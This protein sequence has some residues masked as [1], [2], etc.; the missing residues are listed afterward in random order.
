[1]ND[2]ARADSGTARLVDSDGRALDAT[3]H[4][5]DSDSILVVGF[6]DFVRVEMRLAVTQDALVGSAAARSDAATERDSAGH[7]VPFR[8][9]WTMEARRT[10]CDSVP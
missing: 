3:W 7:S 4:R 2:P 6:N 10:S 5:I 8:R 1:M 9:Q